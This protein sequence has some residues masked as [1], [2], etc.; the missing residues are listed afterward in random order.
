MS[1]YNGDL[2]CEYKGSVSDIQPVSH[3][4][5]TF[6]ENESTKKLVVGLKYDARN[7]DVYGNEILGE[8]AIS[9]DKYVLYFHINI[10]H[11]ENIQSMAVRD[12]TIR[13]ALADKIRNILMAERALFDTYKELYD[14][15]IIVY[16]KSSLPYY[17]KVESWGFVHN[18]L[19]NIEV[20]FFKY[21]RKERE[22]TKL[23]LHPYIKERIIE[24]YKEDR[25]YSLDVVSLD[26]DEIA[27]N[28]EANCILRVDSFNKN[29]EIYNFSVNF[30][31]DSVYVS[32]FIFLDE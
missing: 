27:C 10:K 28:Y 12:I 23:L 31:K 16:F 18:Y 19:Q 14:S 29:K 1:V 7:T 15:R 2:I 26:G 32:R 17:N 3:R 4:R 5:Y 20:D 30:S 24:I 25:D 21:Y 11:N 9:D 13:E 6:L 8:W 22:I